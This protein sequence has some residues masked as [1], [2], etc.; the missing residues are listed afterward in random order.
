MLPQY[1]TKTNAYI[2]IGILIELIGM[3]AF[4]ESG[5]GVLL[6]LLGSGLFIAGC[7]FYAKGKGYPVERW[8]GCLRCHGFWRLSEIL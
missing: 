5:I 2:G 3:I 6:K 7:V 4:P 8:G 1:K